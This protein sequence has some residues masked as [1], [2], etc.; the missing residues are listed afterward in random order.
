MDFSLILT[1]LFQYFGYMVFCFMDYSLIW[2]ILAG[3][4]VVHISGIGCTSGYVAYLNDGT[5]RVTETFSHLAW[6]RRSARFLQSSGWSTAPS[7]V[8]ISCRG[9]RVRDSELFTRRLFCFRGPH[10]LLQLNSWPWEM[11]K[12]PCSCIEPLWP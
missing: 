9:K 2:T 5:S 6:R 8:I 11:G 3:T 1:I 7:P 10:F 12:Y 4:N